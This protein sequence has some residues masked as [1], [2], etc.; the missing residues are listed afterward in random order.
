VPSLVPARGD[1]RG[2]C[3][4]RTASRPAGNDQRMEQIFL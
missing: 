4:E 2:A 1:A 3:A